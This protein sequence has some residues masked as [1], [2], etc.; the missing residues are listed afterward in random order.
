MSSLIAKS[1]AAIKGKR[2]VD[3]FVQE[4]KAD[5]CRDVDPKYDSDPGAFVYT[6][7]HCR[8]KRKSSRSKTPT[9]AATA[10]G[11]A[12]AA[13]RAVDAAEIKALKAVLRKQY[14]HKGI[15]RIIADEKKTGYFT[16]TKMVSTMLMPYFRAKYPDPEERYAEVRK[17]LKLKDDPRFNVLNDVLFVL[18][19]LNAGPNAK[20]LK[21]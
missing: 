21:K 4:R 5:L 9:A 3:A 13:A 10:A 8:P 2:D 16:I 14:A 6:R 15:E 1:R 7:D 20:S 18:L 12:M 19:A 17:H 11:D